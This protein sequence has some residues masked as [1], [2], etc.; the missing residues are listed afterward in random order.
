MMKQRM[1]T[2]LTAAVLTL[3]LAVGLSACGGES[4]ESSK[5]ATPEE[6]LAKAQE[7]MDGVTSMGY[8]MTM[9][10]SMGV[11][12]MDQTIEVATTTSAEAVLSPLTMKA[13]MTVDMGDLGSNTDLTMYVKEED[14]T[15][16]I[17][18]GVPASDGSVTWQTSETASME[19]L[20]SL[21]GKATMD[22]YLTS[23][24]SF[25]EGVTETVGDVEAT[26]YDGVISGEKMEEVLQSSGV[27]SQLDKMGMGDVSSMLTGLGD[28]PVSIWVAKDTYYPV[29]YEMDMAQ[30]MQSIM[31]K[32]ISNQAG[33]DVGLT[34]G[35]M[36]VSMVMR[37]FNAIGEIEIPPEAFA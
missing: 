10:M 34:V 9:T 27:L 24:S 7:A 22:L 13:E 18:T 8:D 11:E 26:R 6:V 5:P 32:A 16:K 33:V 23:A 28:L 17:A 1:V 37:D 12:G 3:I 19:D 31:E 25:T 15:Y 35:K 21:D 14:G 4:G 2:R 20:A 36:D 29:K 30:M